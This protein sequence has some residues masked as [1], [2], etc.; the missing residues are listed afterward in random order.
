MI[1]TET[2]LLFCVTALALILTPGPNQIYIVARSTSQGR[3]AG[4][5]SVLGVETGT[6]FHVA[7]ASL[8]LSAVLASSAVAFSVV[9][10]A[11]AAYLIYLGIRTWRSKADA[12]ESATPG[13]SSGRRIF[14]QGMLT[15][16]LNP[17]V[18]LFFLA[19]LPQFVDV[20]RGHVTAQ[21]LILGVVFT[22]MGLAVDLVVASLASSAGDWL[23]RRPGARRAHK[24]ITGGVYVSLGLGTAL[25]GWGGE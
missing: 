17:K 1:D 2:L 5:L 6:L 19:F 15:N 3:R 16:I 18:A 12:P 4:F 11:G 24:W 21:M 10:Y 7:A 9:K 20:S 13:E 8:G 22:V 23:R 14:A 25:A